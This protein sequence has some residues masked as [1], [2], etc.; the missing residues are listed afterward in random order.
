MFIPYNSCTLSAW[1]SSTISLINLAADACPLFYQRTIW[2]PKDFYPD[3]L[4]NTVTTIL[5]LIVSGWMYTSHCYNAATFGDA[6]AASCIGIKIFRDNDTNYSMDARYTNNNSIV[7]SLG[8]EQYIDTMLNTPVNMYS[9]PLPPDVLLPN[10]DFYLPPAMLPLQVASTSTSS[11]WELAS[12]IL[13]PLYPGIGPLPPG[14][15][16]G[17]HSVFGRRLGIPFLDIDGS[18]YGWPLSGAE[19]LSCY[20]IPKYIH[21][22][23]TTWPRLDVILDALL[24]DCLPLRMVDC[25]ASSVS[26]IDRVYDTQLLADDDMNHGA[27]CLL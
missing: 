8:Y 17:I 22:A 14:Q 25:I 27:R 7:V 23:S 15:V 10:P 21:P 16:S 2:V 5:S 18:M 3:S 24:P 20:S 1:L 26:R 19:L 11:D 4:T 13:H 12:P 6:V 9:I